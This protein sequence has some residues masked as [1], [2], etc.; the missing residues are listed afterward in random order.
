VAR[1]PL[2]DPEREEPDPP[3][4]GDAGGAGTGGGVGGGVHPNVYRAI[5]NHPGALRGFS[6][7]G[8]FVY[9]ESSLTPAH[10]ELAYLTATVANRCHY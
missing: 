6:A 8:H 2:V 10:R 4:D 1:I 3:R 7:F 9:A 5:A